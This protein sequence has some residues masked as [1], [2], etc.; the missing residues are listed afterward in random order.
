MLRYCLQSDFSESLTI[1]FQT[2]QDV[3]DL[4]RPG[5]AAMT[6]PDPKSS[7]EGGLPSRHRPVLGDLAHDTLEMDLWALDDDEAD[8]PSPVDSGPLPLESHVP[9]QRERNTGKSRKER[10]GDSAVPAVDTASAAP[11]APPALRVQ[12]NVGKAPQVRRGR[13]SSVSPSIPE[14]D[15]DNLDQWDEAVS[16]EDA[17]EPTQTVAAPAFT[18]AEPAL[19]PEPQIPQPTA[20]PIKPAESVVAA[21]EI[22]EFSIPVSGSANSVSLRPHLR[23]NKIERA[24]ILAL[25]ILLLGLGLGAYVF[26]F[27]RLPQQSFYTDDVDFPV[28][29]KLIVVKGAHSYWR[30]PV[31]DGPSPDVVRR[32]TVVI[33]VV[34]LT[35]SSGNGV[36]RAVF[37]DEVGNTIGDSISRDVKGEGVLKIVATAGFDNTGMHA[38]YRAGGGK[39]WT[40]EILESPASG[41]ANT[42]FKKLFKMNLSTATR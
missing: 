33:P 32:G 5:R 16:E 25:G 42:G 1:V 14:A 35:T 3:R 30:A 28:K 18:E 40:V 36:I 39:P 15:F 11:P 24:G 12:V 2:G 20:E 26:T 22:D 4:L 38:A 9:P 37:R 8:A 34:E 31:L 19:E 21:P 13:D 10:F 23:L 27:N 29:G 41:S 7:S 17:L 6:T